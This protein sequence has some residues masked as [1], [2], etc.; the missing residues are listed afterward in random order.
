LCS[1]F[2][3]K[4]AAVFDVARDTNLLNTENVMESLGGSYLT[5]LVTMELF[6]QLLVLK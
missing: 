1:I 3:T 5:I 4:K 2:E 6:C